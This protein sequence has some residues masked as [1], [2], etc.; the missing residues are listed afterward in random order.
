MR[1]PVLVLLSVGGLAALGGPSAAASDAGSGPPVSILAASFG[2]PRI[3]VVAGDTV[4]WRNASVRPHTVAATDGS[5]S[6]Q[7]LTP[8][9]A[10]SHRFDAP[11]PV[12]YY[13]QVH[14]FMRAE[15]SVHQLL[16]DPPSDAAAPGRPLELGGR[17]AL[18]T[19]STVSIEATDG[20][21]VTTA[22]VDSA[23][24]FHAT[25]KPG[26]TTSYRAVAGDQ[27]SPPV[28]V[29]VLDRRVEAAARAR[30]R[31]V[32]VDTQVLP[33]SPRATVVLQLHLR[34]RFGWWPVRRVR[35]D[36]ASRAHFRL[37][38]LRRSVRARVLLTARDGATPLAIGPTLRLRPD[39]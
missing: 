37:H 35:L 24:G 27:E 29:R 23:G 22:T 2:S 12:A 32:V 33:A 6:S 26:A 31:S 34:E 21:P 14:P 4:T 10:F 30:G 15:V 9:A 5:W 8:R 1:L 39:R 25:V 3:D 38:H 16:L 36:A 18:P 28:E 17:A 19:G 20:T 13:C 11:G 7:R